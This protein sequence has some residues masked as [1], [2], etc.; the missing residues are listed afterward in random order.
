MMSRVVSVFIAAVVTVLATSPLSTTASAA[1][2][3]SL[4]YLA[5]ID[6]GSSGTRL[7]LYANTSGTLRPRAAYVAPTTSRGLSS[8]ELTPQQ[9]GPESITPLLTQLDVYLAQNGISISSVPV[10]LL[11]TAG[12][13]DVRRDDPAAAQAILDSTAQTLA[14][15]GHLVTDNRILPGE[16]EASLAWLD[17]NVVAGTLDHASSSIGTLEVGGASAQVAFRSPTTHGKAVSQLRV[18]GTDVFVVAVSY[19]R[20]G[21]NDA[22]DLMQAANDAGSFCFPNNVAGSTPVIYVPKAVRP[23]NASTAM[24]SWS[25]CAHAYDTVITSVG[26]VR[27]TAAPVPPAQLRTLPGFAGT[28]FIGLGSIPLIFTT[29]GAA[30]AKDIPAAVRAKIAATCMGPGAWTHSAALYPPSL[31]SFADTLCSTSTY[32]Y[33]LAFS[34]KGVGIRS[35]HFTVLD[36]N[37][38]QQPAWTSGYA[39]TRLHP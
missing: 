7:T 28:T 21:G 34:T 5:V 16:Q 30:G 33:E 23:V 27:T 36:P 15:S 39:I 6:A 4:P 25:R 32:E 10:S 3:V 22:R 17:A 29:L 13:R 20:L 2:T 24:Y 1:W 14:A 12:M 38:P 18:N 31:A 26:A 37:A 35:D 8:F 11:A 19:L 9:A